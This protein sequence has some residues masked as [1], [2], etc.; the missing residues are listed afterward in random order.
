MQISAYDGHAKITNIIQDMHG[1]SEG[2]ELSYIAVHVE[3][4]PIKARS[5]K[6]I[7]DGGKTWILQ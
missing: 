2:D 5:R 7:F 4:K 3:D 6:E 1:N